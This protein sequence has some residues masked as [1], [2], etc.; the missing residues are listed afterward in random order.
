MRLDDK[1]DEAKNLAQV[2]R[3][4]REGFISLQISFN[5]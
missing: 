1:A 5:E 4:S 3:K 2:Y